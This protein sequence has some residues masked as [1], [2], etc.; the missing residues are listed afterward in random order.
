MDEIGNEQISPPASEMEK[1]RRFRKLQTNQPDV[2]NWKILE[3]IIKQDVCEHLENNGVVSSSQHMSAENKSCQTN[4]ISFFD[5]ITNLV[6]CGNAM[7][8]VYQDF[9]NALT[10][11][12]MISWLIKW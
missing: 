8:T 4:L 12:P 10:N 5:K 9:N 7:E 6:D 11:S 3:Q 1:K 2:D